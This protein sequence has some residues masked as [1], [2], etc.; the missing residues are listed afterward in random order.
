MTVSPRRQA[1]PI[2]RSVERISETQFPETGPLRSILT[3]GNLIF[4]ELH[5]GFFALS[6]TLLFVLN[7]G[8]FPLGAR[9]SPC[10]RRLFRWIVCFLGTSIAWF[11]RLWQSMFLLFY[12]CSSL[13]ASTLINTDKFT[14]PSVSPIMLISFTF[15]FWTI[16]LPVFDVVGKLKDPKNQH[17]FKMPCKHGGWIWLNRNR[18]HFSPWKRH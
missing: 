9:E 1:A 7:R 13:R 4:H 3:N 2:S 11:D 16:A 14:G 17:C 6:N 8:F 10:A 5:W 12:P 15:M 18:P